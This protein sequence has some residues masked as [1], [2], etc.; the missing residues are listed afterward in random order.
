MPKIQLSRTLTKKVWHKLQTGIVPIVTSSDFSN[1]DE[2]VQCLNDEIHTNSY[3]PGVGHGFLGVEKTSGVTRFVPILGKEDMAVY[4]QL[5]GELGDQVLKNV[6]GIYG[7]WQVVPVRKIS[8]EMDFSERQQ[9]IATSYQQGYFSDTLS[10][11][12]WFQGFQRYS[13]LV[14]DLVEEGDFGNFV[15]VTDIANFYD[16]IDLSRLMAKLLKELPNYREHVDL[17]NVFLSFWNRRTTGYQPSSKGIPQE[18]I[19]DGSRNLAHFYLQDFDEKFLEYCE[20]HELRYIRWADDMLIFGPSPQKIEA[21]IHKASRYLLVEGLNLSAPKTKIFGKR[22]FSDYRGLDILKTIDD[23]DLEQYRKKRSKIGT[24]VDQIKIDT[25]FR[26]SIGFLSWNKKNIRGDDSDF[27]L[28]T[29]RAHPHLLGTLNTK[30]LFG[31]IQTA[32][33][34]RNMFSV[35]GDLSI[36]RNI[37]A[38]KALVSAMIRQY[39]NN[40]ASLGISHEAQVKLLYRLHASADDSEILRSLCVPAALREVSRSQ[41]TL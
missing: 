4:Y 6:P 19:S 41:K 31:L 34:S 32:S 40:L 3:I 29:L 38:P 23:R 27:L 33:S 12:A 11:A 18:I 9:A 14:R 36:S 16:S 30:Q 25:I 26:A 13:Q 15:G 8:E 10:N 20:S 28:S 1:L 2:V 17:L 39:H 37:T 5:C 35:I 7:G 22:Q 21:A 24:K